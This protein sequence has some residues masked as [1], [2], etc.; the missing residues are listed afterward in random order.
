MPMLQPKI[1]AKNK[2]MYSR[3]GKETCTGTEGGKVI[4]VCKGV[5]GAYKGVKS[6]I[7]SKRCTTCALY[8]KWDGV[9]CPCCNFMLR[10]KTRS[11]IQSRYER[12]RNIRN[13][14]RLTKGD[15]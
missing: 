4:M 5:C 15:Q 12:L 6:D 7:N 13:A 9:Y 8:V 2:V 1:K 3:K 11:A 14:E 10:V